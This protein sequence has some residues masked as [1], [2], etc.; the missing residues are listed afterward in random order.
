MT[1][2]LIEEIK[3]CDI[4]GDEVDK[5]FV[6]NRCHADICDHCCDDNIICRNCEE[7][8]YVPKHLHQRCPHDHPDARDE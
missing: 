8:E 3:I 7:D 5:L 4:C 6:C 1:E 2:E